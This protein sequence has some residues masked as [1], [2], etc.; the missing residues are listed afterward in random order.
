MCN[1]VLCCQGRLPLDAAVKQLEDEFGIAE[2]AKP[3]ATRQPKKRANNHATGE[4]LE[5]PP[6]KAKH[7]NKPHIQ[8][9][10]EAMPAICSENQALVDQLVTLG[11][12]ELHN[13]RTQRGIARM[14]AAKQLHD[15]ETVISSGAQARQLDRI[16]ASAAAKIDAI[17]TEGLKGAMREYEH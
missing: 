9:Q 13:G 8:E 11:E 4:K 14:R 17:L 3:A 2:P 10:I 16:G 7:A 1:P 15:T 5:R 6:K 12:F